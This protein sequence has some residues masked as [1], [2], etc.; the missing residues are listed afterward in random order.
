MRQLCL[1]L[2]GVSLYSFFDAG[3]HSL[4]AAKVISRLRRAFDVALSVRNLFNSP[5]AAQ[6]AE[7]IDT[8]KATSDVVIHRPIA[9]FSHEELSPLA[10]SQERLFFLDQ[11]NPGNNWWFIHLSLRISGDLNLVALNQAINDIRY[12]HSMLRSVFPIRDGVPGIKV[13]EFIHENIPHTSLRSEPEPDRALSTHFGT[14]KRVFDLTKDRP[15]RIHVYELADRVHVLSMTLHHIIY[16]GYSLAIIQ[17]ELR[18]L[19]SA[20]CRDEIAQ[21]PSLPIEVCS[22]LALTLSHSTYCS[23]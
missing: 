23:S 15:F 12:R 4:L 11:L 1:H 7:V 20:Y 8:K 21:L 18:A 22:H 13:L 6:L 5:C 14:D 19:Y 2:T 9:K 10:F 3:G 17:R 16:D